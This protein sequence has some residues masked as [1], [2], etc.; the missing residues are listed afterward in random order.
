LPAYSKSEKLIRLMRGSGQVVKVYFS[1]SED[2][3]GVS[4]GKL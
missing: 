2:L 4:L 3:F 1:T